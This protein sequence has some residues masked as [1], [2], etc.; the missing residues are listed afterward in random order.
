M[1]TQRPD[2]AELTQRLTGTCALCGEQR[3]VSRTETTNRRGPWGDLQPCVACIRVASVRVQ[4]GSTW[5]ISPQNCGGVVWLVP[6]EGEATV[7]QG[8]ETVVATL[9]PGTTEPISG[10]ELY[11]LGVQ[12]GM[13]HEH[14][15]RRTLLGA[16]G[17]PVFTEAVHPKLR[18]QVARAATAMGWRVKSDRPLDRD[19]TEVVLER[20]R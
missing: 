8:W 19:W 10:A 4:D 16:A 6:T 2:P 15:R 9:V 13:F 11:A 17:D 20:V 18:E 1:F 5:G 14:L 12:Y 3:W 7:R